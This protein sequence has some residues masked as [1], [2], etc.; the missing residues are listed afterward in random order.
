MQ[1]ENAYDFITY[2]H[3]IGSSN[4]CGAKQF[5]GG[6]APWSWTQAGTQRLYLEE[7]GDP[8]SSFYLYN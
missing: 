2:T 7:K 1:H 6:F 4:P 3:G 5:H 8:V